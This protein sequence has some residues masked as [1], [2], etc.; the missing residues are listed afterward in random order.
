MPERTRDS[1]Q[2]L[3]QVIFPTGDILTSSD[4]LCLPLGNRSIEKLVLDALSKSNDLRAQARAGQIALETQ[5]FIKIAARSQTN[6]SRLF[7]LARSVV[8]GQG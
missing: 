4:R 1:S 3:R 6:Q 8:M 5:H 7:A 2:F